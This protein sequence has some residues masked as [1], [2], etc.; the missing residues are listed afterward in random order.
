MGTVIV[1]RP[2]RRPAPAFPEG[3][4]VLDAPP[5]I[6]PPTGRAWGQA[7]MM[8]PMLAGSAAMALMFAGTGG[9]GSTLRWVTGG[10]FGLS[11]IGMLSTQLGSYSG[12]PSKQQMAGQRR[13]YMRHLAQLRRR[14][15]GAVRTQREAMFYR[16]P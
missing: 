9:A 2:P 14:T 12:Q 11:A 10:L 4:L 6:P 13:E 5:T 16:H 7:M 3:E 15:R 1:K 8:L